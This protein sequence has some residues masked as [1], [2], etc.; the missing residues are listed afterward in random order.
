MAVS[1]N[2]EIVEEARE[3]LQEGDPLL[4]RVN[5]VQQHHHGDTASIKGII[6]IAHTAYMDENNRLHGDI[7]G[8]P[9]IG[10]TDAIERTLSTF[11]QDD[12]MILSEASQKSLYYFAKE[13]DL[14]Q[15]IIYIDDARDEHIPILK[16]FRNDGDSRPKHITVKDGECLELDVNGRPVIFASSVTPLRDLQGQA[17]SRALML[18]YEKPDPMT[19]RE[20]KRKIRAKTRLGQLNKTKDTRKLQ[21]LQQVVEILKTEGTPHVMIPFDAREP[22]DGTR[23]DTG[24]FQRLIASS[25]YIHQFQ[26]PVLKVNGERYVLAIHEDLEAAAEFWI[27]FNVSQQFKIPPKALEILKVLPTVEPNP[28]PGAYGSKCVTSSKVHQ[29]TKIPQSTCKA[30]LDNLYEAGLANRVQIKAPGS[31]WA[32]WIDPDT[33][34]LLA[35]ESKASDKVAGLAIFSYTDE[36]AK[37]MAEFSPDC[38]EN[39]ICGFFDDLAHRSENI[40]MEFREGGELNIFSEDISSTY[41]AKWQAKSKNVLKDGDNLANGLL[42][43]SSEIPTDGDI[44]TTCESGQIPSIAVEG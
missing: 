42:A 11:P 14:A 29:V 5:Y 25:A 1:T 40:I 9:A 34:K 13:N 27:A 19:E 24:Q 22:T 10:K 21:V 41:L 4:E 8:E 39:S 38:L 43:H 18:T 23:R 32:Y 20:I 30:Y 16:T 28:D 15:K 31:P 7:S 6:L 12:I 33:K 26:R 17:T 3:I 36:L 2:E 35:K 44:E 37:Y